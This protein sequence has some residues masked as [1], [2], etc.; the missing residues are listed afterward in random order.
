MHMKRNKKN[1]FIN[2]QIGDYTFERV[3]TFKYLGTTISDENTED[4][5]IQARILNASKSLYL[6]ICMPKD[7]V[8]QTSVTLLKNQ[9]IQNHHPPSINVWK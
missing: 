6:H 5:E 1:D 9:N 8:I 2:I 3:S 4:I 7:N